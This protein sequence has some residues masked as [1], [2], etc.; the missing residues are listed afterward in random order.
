MRPISEKFQDL[1]FAD[2]KAHPEIVT[3]LL[4]GD[5]DVSLILKK[6]GDT[7]RFATMRTYSREAIR[8]VEQAR[9][10]Y[11]EKEQQG[12]T[13]DDAVADFRAFQREI[14]KQTD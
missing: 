13:R 2:L 6:H 11:A 7:V 3:N 9:A 5:E 8:T 10:E 12:Y 14:A 4:A 1:P